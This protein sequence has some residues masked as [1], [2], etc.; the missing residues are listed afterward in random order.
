MKLKLKNL[1]EQ[2]E[3]V[4]ALGSRNAVIASEAMETFAA[5]I[6]PVINKVLTTAGTSNLIYTATEFD[7]DDSPSYP[8]DLYYNED[9]GLIPVWSQSMAG[10]LPTAQVEGMAE[11]KISTYRLD[12]AVSFAKKYARKARLDIISK[13]LERMAQ[14]VLIKQERNAWAVVLKALGEAVTNGSDHIITSGTESVFVPD[15]ISRLMTLV[16]RINMSFSQ[17]TPANF[18][19]KG[20]TDLFVSPE[21]KEQIR[22]FAYNPINTVG[23]K[24]TG[25]VALPDNI[26]TNIYN[27]AGTDEIFGVHI[28]DLVELGTTRKY[29][30]LFSQYAPANCGHGGDFSSTDDEV[31]IGLD[32][33][34]EAFIR[35]VARQFDSGGTFTVQ[36]DDQWPVRAEKTGFYGYLEEGRVC[37]D[38]KAAVAI[39]V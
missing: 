22:G 31:L 13:A 21:I 16:K 34:R 3:L 26:R 1:P 18:D 11:M 35:P 6:G 33:T 36:P 4:K 38:G 39:I 23:S 30:V 9:A 32:L 12:S 37:I 8:L 2:I 29:N 17:Q 28:T 5:F 25:P 19:S 10:G 27:A 14:E 15:D 20:L 24:S 7:E